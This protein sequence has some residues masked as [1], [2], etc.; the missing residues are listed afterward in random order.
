MLNRMRGSQTLFPWEMA[1]RNLDDESAAK[2]PEGVPE[3]ISR[4][5]ASATAA[6]AA[7]HGMQTEMTAGLARSFQPQ[8][9]VNNS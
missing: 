5:L 1:G 6:V 3:A 7:R 2:A 4:P 8:L 9:L